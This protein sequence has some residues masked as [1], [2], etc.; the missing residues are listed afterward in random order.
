MKYYTIITI[1]EMLKAKTDD[2]M[3]MEIIQRIGPYMSYIIEIMYHNYGAKYDAAISRD[4]IRAYYIS[5]LT[6][7]IRKYFKPVYDPRKDT[8]GNY[9]NGFTYITAVSKRLVK[10]FWFYHHK[11]RRI[12]LDAMRQITAGIENHMDATQ[13]CHQQPETDTFA[14]LRQTLVAHFR[15]PVI[16]GTLNS[17][18]LLDDVMVRHM[19]VEQ[20]AE[21]Y[22]T[23]IG[24]TR[25]FLREHVV[26]VRIRQ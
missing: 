24:E 16:R 7:A 10:H 23:S 17:Q 22:V 12:P 14:L 6:I 9:R 2:A 4:D 21:K 5:S 11:K 13:S 25:E 15:K 3:L 18:T 1:E 26:C 19:T 8:N 20:I